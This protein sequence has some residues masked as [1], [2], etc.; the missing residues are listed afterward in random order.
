MVNKKY[1]ESV[2]LFTHHELRA[3]IERAA[4]QC[5]HI[6]GSYNGD[7]FDEQTSTRCIIVAK[8]KPDNINI[9]MNFKTTMLLFD[10][11]S[12]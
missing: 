6:F 5:E 3:M 10:F 1:F 11:I 4:M 9:P 7:P 2:R 12:N 8:K